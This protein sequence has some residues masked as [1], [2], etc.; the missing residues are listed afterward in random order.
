MNG[1]HR[2]MEFV[3]KDAGIAVVGLSCRVPNASSPSELWQGLLER[4]SSIS[5]SVPHHV[6]SRKGVPHSGYAHALKYGAFLDNALDFDAPFFHISDTEAEHMDPQQRLAL[7]LVWAAVEDARITP[8]EL[9]G[10]S[11]GV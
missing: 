11:V 5:V 3:N 1:R 8:D 10:E 4:R 7:E 9:A 6:S 2:D